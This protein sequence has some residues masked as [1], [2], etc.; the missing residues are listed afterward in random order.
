[1]KEIVIATRNFKKLKEINRIFKNAGIKTLSLNNFPKAPE[2]VEDKKDFKGNAA[3]KARVV[4]RFTRGRLTLAD[5][6]GLEVKA[7]G[8]KPGVKSARY[9]GMKKKDMDNNLKLLKV[10]KQQSGKERSAQ[11]RCIVALAISG[12]VVRIVEGTSR[13]KIGFTMEGKSG[14]GYDPVFIPRGYKK[15]FS[16]LGN[17]IKDRL[18]H[19]AKALRKAKKFIQ[20]Y[21]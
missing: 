7:L 11:F 17:K 19:R 15:T 5:D 20:R 2:V 9:A 8:G 3:K 10:L 16:Q 4:S 18:S 14:F 6:S 1:M 21:L 12:K 13:G